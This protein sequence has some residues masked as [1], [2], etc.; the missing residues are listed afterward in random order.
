MDFQGFNYVKCLVQ[1]SEG[2]GWFIFEIK[3]KIITLVRG[4]LWNIVWKLLEFGIIIGLFIL[5]FIPGLCPE[6]KGRKK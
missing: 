3:N 4:I 2:I 6:K 1:M 5:S